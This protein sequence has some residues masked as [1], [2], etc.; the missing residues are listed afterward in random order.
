M[1]LSNAV[2]VFQSVPGKTTAIRRNICYVF[3]E[4]LCKQ[5]RNII[6][7]ISCGSLRFGC[8]VKDDGLATEMSV[9]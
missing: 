1:K 6:S 8:V 4:S 2:A 9:L 7:T 5:V 3:D